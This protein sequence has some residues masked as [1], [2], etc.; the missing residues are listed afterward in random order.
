MNRRP[1][2]TILF[3]YLLPLLLY[4]RCDFI[5]AITA[6]RPHLFSSSERRTC[7]R[8]LRT[9]RQYLMENEDIADADPLPVSHLAYPGI[10]RK[11]W[12]TSFPCDIHRCSCLY[13]KLI[14]INRAE[15]P[16]YIN[17]CTCNITFERS[18]MLVRELR[19]WRS[20]ASGALALD[21][22][23]RLKHAP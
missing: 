7:R 1:N 13:P 8:Y 12:V 2:Y 14:A 16:S 6:P 11:P 9:V 3:S 21:Y 10:S 18:R 22:P 19:L 5:R 20:P 15:A 17:R 4:R 23:L